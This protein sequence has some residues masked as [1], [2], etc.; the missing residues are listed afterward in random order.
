V[1]P[2]ITGKTV[3]A[4]VGTIKLF[5]CS[6]KQVLSLHALLVQKHKY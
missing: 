2:G 4:L 6:S 3:V 1:H 5:A